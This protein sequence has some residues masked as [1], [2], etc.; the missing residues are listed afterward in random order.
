MGVNNASVPVCRLQIAISA[1]CKTLAIDLLQ[2]QGTK[3]WIYPT[4]THFAV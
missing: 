4:C 3:A 2:T 1:S